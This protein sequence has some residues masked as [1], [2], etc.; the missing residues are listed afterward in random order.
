MGAMIIDNWRFKHGLVSFRNNM[1]AQIISKLFASD[2]RAYAIK[3]L[4]I[5]SSLD[6][7]ANRQKLEIVC[8]SLHQTRG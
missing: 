7:R 5:Y 3:I 1:R 6:Y 2:I 8:A 4:M